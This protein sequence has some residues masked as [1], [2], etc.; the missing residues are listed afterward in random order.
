MFFRCSVS[1]IERVGLLGLAVVIPDVSPHKSARGCGDA[2]SPLSG[3]IIEKESA[4]KS[5]LRLYKPSSD[6]A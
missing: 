1:H 2:D 6:N 5:I 4:V 3:D